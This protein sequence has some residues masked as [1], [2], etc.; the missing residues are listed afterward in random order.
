MLHWKLS[1]TERWQAIGLIKAEIN[2]R[3]VGE[4]LKAFYNELLNI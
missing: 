4:N 3:R 1:D 2:H